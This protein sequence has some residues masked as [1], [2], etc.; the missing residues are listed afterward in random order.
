[1]SDFSSA[2]LSKQLN[3]FMS[4][5]C[6]A[7]PDGT[8]AKP[9]AWLKCCFNHDLAYWRGGTEKERDIADDSLKVCLRDTFSNTL[10]ILMYMGVRF[11]G[12]PNYKTSY[13][14]GFGWNYDRGYLPLS[15]EELKFSKE[16]SPKKGESMDKYLIKK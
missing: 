1:M 11:W 2:P 13:R 3:P 4:D 9:K 14:W 7:W 15:E 16:V 12:K 5:G 10:A 8:Q 6:S